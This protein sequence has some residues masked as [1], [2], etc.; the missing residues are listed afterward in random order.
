LR[1]SIPPLLGQ[2]KPPTGLDRSQFYSLHSFNDWK[3]GNNQDGL[4]QRLPSH[5]TA[6]KRAIEMDIVTRLEPGSVASLL[7]STCLSTSITFTDNFFSYLTDTYEQL[8][9]AAFTK[10][11]AWSLTTALGA[12]VCQEVHKDSGALLRSISVTK[13]SADRERLCVMMLWATLRSHKVMDEYMRWEFKDHPT[14]AS[15]YVKFL[16]TNSGFEV[17][18]ALEAKTD[19]IKKELE[20]VKKSATSASNAAET[21]KNV[22]NEAKKL[23]DKAVKKVPP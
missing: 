12:R 10:A 22:A 7:A 15:E 6:A 21:A 19:A 18:S 17:V 4:I 2:G 5:L 3:S 20:S 11:K 23:A 9:K 13:S 1:D 16:A 8:V 14:I